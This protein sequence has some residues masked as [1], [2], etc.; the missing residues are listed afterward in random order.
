MNVDLHSH[1]N[2]SDGMLA[3]AALV[4]RAAARGV[5]VLALTDHDTLTG[6]AEAR[7]AASGSGLRFIDGVEISLTWRGRTLHVLGLGVD[8]ADA[9][10]RR[11]LESVR[12]GRLERARAIARSLEDAGV[13]GA[14]EGALAHAAN[15]LMVSRTHFA[16]HLVASGV[17]PDARAAFRSYLTPGK[18]GYV[19]HRWGALE[20]AVGWIRHAGGKAVL[21]HPARYGLSAGA[22]DALLVEFRAVGGEG[23]EVV[24]GSHS[25]GDAADYTACALHGGW[26][27]SRGSDFHAPAEGAEL[28]SVAALDP[29]LQPVW[30]ALGL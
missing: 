27:A 24:S 16:R 22:R 12:A 17:V 1:S 6:L 30:R 2:H 11:G 15:P 3:P 14:L 13:P 19:E 26:L 5:D 20:E 25:E 10:L 4:E 23:L 21:A 18:P 7:E 29:R 8:P 9:D 28:G